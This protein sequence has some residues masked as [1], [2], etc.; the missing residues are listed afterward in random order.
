MSLVKCV[1]LFILNK[2]AVCKLIPGKKHFFREC[3]NCIVALCRGLLVES[4][5]ILKKRIKIL[6]IF[7]KM[8]VLQI[9]LERRAELKQ[10]RLLTW[11]ILSC[12]PNKIPIIYRPEREHPLPFGKGCS[13]SGVFICLFQSCFSV[14]SRSKPCFF[15]KKQR[16]LAVILVSELDGNIGQLVFRI[17]KHFFLRHSIG[18]PE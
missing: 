15:L 12:A 14:F 17:R 13:L 11:K 5:H 16:V 10:L 8:N 2:L 18:D 6:N 9:T 7:V 1:V 3:Y 4:L